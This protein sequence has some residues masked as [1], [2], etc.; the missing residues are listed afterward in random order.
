MLAGSVMLQD[1][2]PPNNL[3]HLGC[4]CAGPVMERIGRKR[5]LM[6]VSAAN[7]AIGFALILLANSAIQIYIGR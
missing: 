4:M 3:L 6:W 7:Y 2:N 5:A 1:S